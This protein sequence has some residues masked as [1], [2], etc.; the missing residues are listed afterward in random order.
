MKKADILFWAVGNLYMVGALFTSLHV[1]KP[2]A[3]QDDLVWHG[4]MFLGQTI[5]MA[6]VW[7]PYWILTG[8]GALVT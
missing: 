8:L 4:G 7:I 2:V 1:F 3:S 5:L 6:F